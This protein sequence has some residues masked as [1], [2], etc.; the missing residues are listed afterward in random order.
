MMFKNKRFFDNSER[1]ATMVEFLLS[2]ALAVVVFPFLLNFQTDRIERA[3]NIRVANDL[4]IVQLSLERYIDANKER[5]MR[6]LGK[7]ITRVDL[8]TLE[9]YGVPIDLME[10]YDNKIQLRILKSKTI[11]DQTVVQGIAVLNDDEISAL[12]TREII[13]LG[14]N[15]IGFIEGEKAYGAFGSWETKAQNLGIKKQGGIIKTTRPTVGQDSYLWRIPSD[16]EEDATMLSSLDLAFRD[17]QNVNWLDGMSVRVDEF[18]RSKELLADTIN[19]QS[20]TGIDNNLRAVNATVSGALS[21]DSKIMQITNTLTLSESAKINVFESNNLWV[22]ELNVSN[23]SVVEYFDGVATLKINRKLDMTDG[24]ISAIYTTVGFDGSIA[25][26]LVVH[27]K[28]EDSSDSSYFWDA[29][30]G[31]ARFADVTF[32]ELNRMATELMYLDKNS[33]TYAKQVFNVPAN[34][35]NATITDFINALHEIENRVKI[36]YQQLNLK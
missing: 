23:L 14:E 19:F 9:S 36:K 25:P 1:G 27:S 5:L 2:L 34:N 22:N 28:I 8:E 10:K 33:D 20:R 17:V 16:N 32:A 3:N 29:D 15:N 26:R 31:T 35:Q 13:N 11:D 24:I 12:R 4:E 6:T 7:T 30:N 18:F 21:A